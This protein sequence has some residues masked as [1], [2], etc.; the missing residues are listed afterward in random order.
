[1]RHL[2]VGIIAGA[3]LAGCGGDGKDSSSS[4]DARAIIEQAA[5]ALRDAEGMH[6]TGSETDAEGTTRAIADIDADGDMA[7]TLTL[8][9]DRTSLRQ[10]GDDTYLR[11]G[12]SFWAD[13][14]G[15]DLGLLVDRWI[16]IPS[17]LGTELT[18]DLAQLRPRGL[19]ECLLAGGTFVIRG[20]EQ[21]DG[22]PVTVIEDKGD[23]PGGQPGL[24][25]VAA[26]GRPWLVRLR[27]TGPPRRGKAPEIC[28]HDEDV[29]TT[30]SD[31]RS[32][33]FEQPV[34]ARAPAGAITLPSDDSQLSDA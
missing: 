10:V 30:S 12:K 21:L 33:R 20:H 25:Y 14:G 31:L 7:V 2:W 22:Q 11:A 5:A 1:M 3:L 17:R 15:E 27:A 6:V 23:K 26:R 4:D 34:T 29:P 32:S 13:I 16:H 24:L 18:A 28:G 19:A 9:G 8:N